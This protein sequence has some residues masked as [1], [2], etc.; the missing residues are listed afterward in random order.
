MRSF[1]MNYKG[2]DIYIE[3]GKY[4]AMKI[5]QAGEV[6]RTIPKSESLREAVEQIDHQK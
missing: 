5:N 6:E 2:F 1:I 3:D 4:F